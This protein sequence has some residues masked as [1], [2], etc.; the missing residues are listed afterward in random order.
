MAGRSPSTFGP[1]DRLRS[2]ADF[3]Y[4]QGAGTKIFSKH[5]LLVVAPGKTERPRL[6]L[7]VTTKIDPRA[8]VR[9]RIKRLVREVFRA[10][11]GRLNADYDIIVIA[12]R[13]A[14]HCAKSEVKREMF[15]ALHHNGFLNSTPP[16]AT[17]TP[18][19]TTSDD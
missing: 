17:I 14:Q 19:D 18:T 5:F 2:K 15:G 16:T 6:G 10:E 13:D 11:R 12:R 7:T 3:A 9:N 1:D 4:A 8:V